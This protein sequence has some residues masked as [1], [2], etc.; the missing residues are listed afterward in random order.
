MRR[1]PIGTRSVF[2]GVHCFFLHPLFIA[3]GWWKAYGTAP[4]L[5]GA[6]LIDTTAERLD[7]RN[8]IVREEWQ[9][10]YTSLLDP[11]L[12]LAFLVHDL[13]YLGKPNMDGPEGETH[14]ELGARI[15]R[16]LFGEP[17]GEF[18]LTHSR[19]YAK[20]LGREPSA[21]CL[22]DKWVFLLE[23][24][25]LY[26]PRARWSGELEEYLDVAQHR[27]ASTDTMMNDEERRGMLTRDPQV[28]H[29]SVRA[30]MTRW[31]AANAGGGPDTWTKA[32]HSAT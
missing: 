1:L 8:S 3:A 4:V 11:R 28:W 22:A 9:R 13:G 25:W 16:R 14:P 27:A 2:Y 26:L 6:R 23:P 20:Q 32:R 7:A 18:V 24:A 29:R 15:M 5:V 30:Y 19:Y 12:W 31:I 21:L 17:W 10:V